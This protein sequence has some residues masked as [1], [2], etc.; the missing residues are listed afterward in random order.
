[1]S[2]SISLVIPAH[3]EE[4]AIKAVVQRAANYIACVIV[5]ADGCTDKTA[6]LAENAGAIVLET[7]QR[8]GKGRAM[9]MG[10]Q[11][12]MQK[13]DCQWILFMDGDLQHDAKDIPKFIK[14]VKKLEVKKTPHIELIL[15]SRQPFGSSMPVLRRWANC[16]MT[17]LIAL[18][19]ERK[20]KDSQC[21]FRMAHKDFLN[22]RSWKSHHF[23]IETEML[24]VAAKR[25][26]RVREVEVSCSYGEEVSKI[27]V[28]KDTWRWLSA[29]VKSSLYFLKS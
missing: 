9:C 8:I 11:T 23:E 15:G 4:K 24:F 6:K 10:W 13:S 28:V 20:M 22:S 1:M 17:S 27:A 5:V 12:A 29:F 3:N 14:Q 7:K 21:G 19:I 2:G 16:L 26:W 25:G 18:A